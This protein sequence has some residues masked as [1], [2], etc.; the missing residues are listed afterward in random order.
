MVRFLEFT[1]FRGLFEILYALPFS[2]MTLHTTLRPTV[3]NSANIFKQCHA[4]PVCL[5]SQARVMRGLG[6][7]RSPP[8]HPPSFTSKSNPIPIEKKN[9]PNSTR[10]QARMRASMLPVHY[11]VFDHIVEYCY[12]NYPGAFAALCL[13]S[14][15]FYAAC[16]V[17]LYRD[18]SINFCDPTGRLLLDRV[19]R[20]FSTL[21]P[22]VRSLRLIG[23]GLATGEDWHLVARTLTQCTRLE[24]FSWDHHFSVPS[25]VLDRLR[26]YHPRASF[27]LKIKQMYVYAVPTSCDT[28]LTSFTLELKACRGSMSHRK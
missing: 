22:Y 8:T 14:K 10:S 12:N 25:Y 4:N 17:W 19:S 6:R 11:D 21:S 28:V 26:K 23:C 16:L 15:T 13:T 7:G 20:S 24:S 5:I 3:E 18:I 2:N 1:V 9:T 27:Q